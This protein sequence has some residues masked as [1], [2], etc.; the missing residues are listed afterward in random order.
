MAAPAHI[1]R[2]NGKKGGRPK[3]S[4]SK[5]TKM[6][7]AKE[8]EMHNRIVKSVDALLNSQM[9]LAKGTSFLFKIDVNKSGNQR[10]KPVLVTKQKEIEEFLAGKKEEEK[11]VYYFITTDKP[12]NK[13]IDSMLDR[14]FG[15]AKQSMDL[16][17]GGDKLSFSDAVKTI[18]NGGSQ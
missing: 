18:T 8:K 4:V 17:T 9:V 1:A 16:T 13:A 6:R 12:D 10:G 11:G 3:G 2:E 7:L 14:V 15:K 5:E